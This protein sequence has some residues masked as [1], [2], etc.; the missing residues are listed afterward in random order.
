VESLEELRE[1]LAE[2][3]WSAVMV[4]N[5]EERVITAESDEWFA[6][7]EGARDAA[8]TETD[9]GELPMGV[10]IRG[11]RGVRPVLSWER[12]TERERNA[13]ERVGDVRSVIEF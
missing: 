6:L 7:L 2:L 3:G 1:R 9:D 8:F 10:S 5:G 11:L 4:L 13:D 12:V